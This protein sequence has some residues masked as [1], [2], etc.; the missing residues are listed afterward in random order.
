MIWRELIPFVR[1]L[2][3][4]KSSSPLVRRFA[5]DIEQECMV[6]LWKN[7]A[8][9]RAYAFHIVRSVIVDFSRAYANEP[10]FVGLD[11]I[12]SL[13]ARENPEELAANKE[14]FQGLRQELQMRLLGFSYEEISK[15]VGVPLNTVRTRIFYARRALWA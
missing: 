8:H 11:E 3:R 5:E 2:I 14:Q 13:P 7:E 10:L 15:A 12:A 6:R 1:S 9:S 4:K